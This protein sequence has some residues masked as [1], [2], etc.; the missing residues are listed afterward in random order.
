MATQ[1]ILVNEDL[2]AHM[3]KAFPDKPYK[4]G[5]TLAEVAYNQGTQDPIQHLKYLLQKRNKRGR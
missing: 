3:E 2:I 1:S 4:P 5:A